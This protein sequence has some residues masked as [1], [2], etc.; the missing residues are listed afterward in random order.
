[1][2]II[3]YAIGKQS[4]GSGGITPTGEIQISNNGNYDVTNY[5]T[6]NVNVPN[7]R[8]VI[9]SN[10]RF[11][12]SEFSTLP[13]WLQNADWT[14]CTNA[15]G[16]FQSCSSLTTVTL[17][18][19]QNIQT[20]W[21]TFADCGNL[22]SVS[23]DKMDNATTTYTMF[24]NCG[25]L[26]T[27]N[28]PYDNNITNMQ[29]MFYGCSKLKNIGVFNSDKVTNM[30]HMFW[31]CGQL[32]NETVN[33]MLQVCINATSYTGTKTLTQ[34]SLKGYASVIPSLSNYQAFLDAGWTLD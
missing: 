8:A 15:R 32:T 24:S 2:D 16:K 22:T 13:T 17:T 21:D 7:D 30:Y 5:A 6:A 33:N 29:T 31:G 27:V 12:N 34:I 19:T 3:S 23:I 25:K 4:A 26:E 9:D 28:L 14:T 10:I 18:G 11:A 1:M 20:W